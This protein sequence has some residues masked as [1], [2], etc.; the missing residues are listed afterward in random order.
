MARDSS[1][2]PRTCRRQRRTFVPGS[3]L[4]KSSR[5]AEISDRYEAVKFSRRQVSQCQTINMKCA[6][7]PLRSDTGQL[8]QATVAI[9]QPSAVFR[10]EGKDTDLESQLPAGPGTRTGVLSASRMGIHRSGSDLVTVPTQ[11]FDHPMSVERFHT[12]MMEN[13]QADQSAVQIAIVWHLR[14]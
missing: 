5:C 3:L 14:H 1:D 8:Q 7:T 9:T 11:L 2:E 12:C 10:T 6:L 4:H 13:M